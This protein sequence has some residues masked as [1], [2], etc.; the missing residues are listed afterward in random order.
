[1][2]KVFYF[3]KSIRYFPLLFLEHII[4]SEMI[5]SMVSG[6]KIIPLNFTE[7]QAILY[8]QLHTG[9]LSTTLHGGNVLFVWGVSLSF[10]NH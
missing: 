1:M 10:L 4:Y 5:H 7:G 9:L 8:S 6:V 3:V 2:E